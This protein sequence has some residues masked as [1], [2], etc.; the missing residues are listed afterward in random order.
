[1]KQSVNV[2]ILRERKGLCFWG[3]KI[4]KTLTGKYIKT[5]Y[6]PGLR[7][8]EMCLSTFVKYNVIENHHC[9]KQG[10]KKRSNNAQW[11]HLPSMY[12]TITWK[13]SSKYPG[14]HQNVMIK[15][16]QQRPCPGGSAF[17]LGRISL[18]KMECDCNKKPWLA[19]SFLL[20][21]LL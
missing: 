5:F 3:K 15:H 11:H 20:I 8:W 9:M 7:S 1:M 2:Q 6:L 18:K 19:L 14:F 10:S 16:S 12:I 17:V 13:Q 4:L 21:S